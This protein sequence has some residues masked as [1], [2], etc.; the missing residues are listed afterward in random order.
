ANILG[1]DWLHV[2]DSHNSLGWIKANDIN[3]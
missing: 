2:K 3:G 1:E